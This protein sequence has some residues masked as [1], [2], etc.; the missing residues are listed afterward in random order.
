MPAVT[1]LP[2]FPL[3]QIHTQD[4][5]GDGVPDIVA[6]TVGAGAQVV[7]L[8]NGD[9]TFTIQHTTTPPGGGGVNLSTGGNVVLTGCNSACLSLLGSSGSSG[10]ATGGS[11]VAGTVTGGTSVSITTSGATV[12]GGT[13]TGGTTAKATSSSTGSGDLDDLSVLFLG[14]MLLRRRS[15]RVS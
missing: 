14:I 15:T 11:S 4:E 13:K 3:T 1:Y 7:L 9:G 2:G 12:T 10:S 8:N 6:Y 5:N